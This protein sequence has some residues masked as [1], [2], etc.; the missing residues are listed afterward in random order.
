MA[1]LTRKTDSKG[2]LTLPAD[3]ASCLVTV[4]RSGDELR[5]AKAQR[6]SARRYS[7]RE[8]VSRITP[9][10][11]HPEVKTGRIALPGSWSSAR[12]RTRPQ[13]VQGLG[14]GSAYSQGRVVGEAHPNP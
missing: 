6:V 8:L 14:W 4:E 11:V 9:A 2:R 1:I 5:I 3:L 10:N 13:R 12:L 7:Y